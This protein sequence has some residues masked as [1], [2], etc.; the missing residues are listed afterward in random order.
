MELREIRDLAIAALVLAAV[1]SYKGFDK[2]PEFTIFFPFAI[3][4][5]SVSFLA[6]EMSH[7]YFARKYGYYAVFQLWP[8][9]LGLAAAL[10]IVSNG[11]FIF[12]APGAVVIFAKADLWGNV[13][14]L[15]LKQSGIVSA[16]GPVVNLI[17]AAAFTILGI[18]FG[19]IFF[20]GTVI[21]IWLSLFNLLPL[22]PL[23]GTKVLHWNK[24]IWFALF[25]ISIFALI[26]AM[27]FVV[28]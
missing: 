18:A 17:L 3:L 7:R 26:L 27:V 22:G 14:H 6:H 20:L 24:K 2:I 12:A 8:L 23:D 9:G 15:S 13:K 1:F 21:N 4:F 25:I 28:F 16:A 10:A 11:S 19:Q 5:V